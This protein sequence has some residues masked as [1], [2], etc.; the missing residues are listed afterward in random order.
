MSRKFLA[1]ALGTMMSAPVWAQ[2]QT[3][4]G[5]AGTMRGRAGSPLDTIRTMLERRNPTIDEVLLLSA[6]VGK[7]QEE[8]KAANER[9]RRELPADEARSRAHVTEI[10]RMFE[11]F[12]ARQRLLAHACSLIRPHQ[13]ESEGVLGFQIEG[14]TA[15]Q[16]TS[17][18]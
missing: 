7:W 6:E 17:P 2:G 15:F 8:F 1:I 12:S 16:R 4:V 14:A 18:V 13:G 5:T 11:E 10:M 9:A 3:P